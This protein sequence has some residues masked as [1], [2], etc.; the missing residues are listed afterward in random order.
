MNELIERDL[1][2]A[3]I[4]PYSPEQGI[5]F[6]EWYAREVNMRRARIER[7]KEIIRMMIR[8]DEQALKLLDREYGDTFES[9][10]AS[11]I[12]ARNNQ[13]GGTA[14]SVN[15]AFGRAGYRTQPEKITIVDEASCLTW[16][17]Q[18]GHRDAIKRTPLKSAVNQLVKD[19]QHI[20]GVEV[21]NPGQVFVLTLPK[22][23]LELWDR[24]P[25]ELPGR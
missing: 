9:A 25:A 14:K 20:P 22:D 2:N 11:D 16:L 21:T 5:P 24:R 17:E 18:H 12:Q 10:V 3:G 19:G 6:A 1:Q 15:L 8:Q 7:A 23:V 13:T 4:L